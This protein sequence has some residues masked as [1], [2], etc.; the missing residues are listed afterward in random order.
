MR[1]LS[2]LDSAQGYREKA[3]AGVIK[4]KQRIFREAEDGGVRLG[5]RSVRC[6]LSFSL[7]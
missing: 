5:K 4:K 6:N 7:V 3:S 2:S 1:F